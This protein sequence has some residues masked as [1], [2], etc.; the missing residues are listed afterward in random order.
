[1]RDRVAPGKEAAA[2]I[3]SWRAP[4][5]QESY[6]LGRPLAP[7]ASAIYRKK[8]KLKKRETEKA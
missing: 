1:V 2:C 3:R 6:T 4:Q 8:E 5:L 7:Q